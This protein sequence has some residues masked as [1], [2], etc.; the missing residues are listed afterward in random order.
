M[1]LTMPQIARSVK[2]IIAGIGMRAIFFRAKSEILCYPGQWT[3]KEPMLP[4]AV[5]GSTPRAHTNRLLDAFEP[6]S[7]ARI[8]PHIQP[9]NLVLGDVV[10]EAGGFLEYVYFPKGAVLSL[11]T[12]LANG[13]AIETAN[14]GNEGAFGLFAPD[15]KRL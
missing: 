1:L 4:H 11:L 15:Q 12:V 7:R 3:R 6:S 2:C 8:D 14:I 9:V 5:H 10:C 13:A